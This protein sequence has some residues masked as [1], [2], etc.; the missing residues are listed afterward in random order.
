MQISGSQSPQQLETSAGLKR[1]LAVV[2]WE[3]YCV[4]NLLKHAAAVQHLICSRR[5]ASHSFF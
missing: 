5:S 1:G 4:L 3:K 2:V